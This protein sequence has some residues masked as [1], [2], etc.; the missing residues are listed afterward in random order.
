MDK[1]VERW[2]MFE[3][4]VKG[5]SEGNPFTEHQIRGVFK[6][7]NEEICTDGFYDGDGIYRIR[8]MP[9]F[10]GSYSYRIQ[11]DFLSDPVEGTF[12]VIPAGEGNHGPAQVADKYHFIYADK[13]PYYSVGT[14]CYV[15]NHQSDERIAETLETLKESGFNKLRFCVFPKHFDYN[16]GEPRS[17]PYEG[18]PMDSSVLTMDNFHEYDRA[19]EDNN[20]DL[21][22]FNPEHFRHIEYCISKLQDL[23]I[24]ADIIM[25]HPYDRWGFAYMTKEQDDLYW[26]YAAARFSAYRNVWWSAANEYDLLKAKTTEDW[27]RYGKILCEKDPYHHLRSIHHCINSYDHSRP[28]I[29]HVSIQGNPAN[30]DSLRS[31]YQKPVVM[32]EMGYEGNIEYT[33]GN[34]SA[35]EMVRRFWETVCRGGY[36]GHGETYLHPENILWWSHGGKLHGESWKRIK[37]L[38]KIMEETP[39]HG[40]AL[41]EDQY[42]IL[43]AAPEKECDISADKPKSYYIYY[44]GIAQPARTDI[45]MDESAAYRVEIIDTWNMTIE[46]AGVHTGRIRLTLPGKQY[47][48]V[49]LK[50]VNTEGSG[51]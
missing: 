13:T 26:N 27:E 24:E 23:G 8:F 46:D 41:A 47:M 49:R 40:M 9:S 15:W 12:E 5:P 29:T 2:G 42:G 32:D 33:W 30:V 34:S 1:K 45:R 17:Y 19:N 31:R 6:S 11:A 3:A 50:R 44:Y 22:R 35:A 18:T 20:F 39:G 36:P 51:I 10:T 38:K 37:F 43:V 16:L 4:E 28:W 21:F 48:A 25:M 7:E 14:T